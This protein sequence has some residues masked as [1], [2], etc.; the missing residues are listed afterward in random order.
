MDIQ[1]KRGMLEVCVLAAVKDGESYG[2]R[3]IKDIVSGF[4]RNNYEVVPDRRDALIRAVDMSSANDTLIC[5]GK[6]HEKYIIDKCGK[7]SF[8]EKKILV[9]ALEKKYG[10]VSGNES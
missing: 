1:L 3:I 10:T 7:H 4:Y 8:D 6:G 5:C 9:E 2:Y